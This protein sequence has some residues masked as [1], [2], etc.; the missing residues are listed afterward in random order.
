MSDVS[1]DD[2]I[3]T[4]RQHADLI[5]G[6]RKDFD[7]MSEGMTESMADQ[8]RMIRDTRDALLGTYGT[9]GLVETVRGFAE[10]RNAVTRAFWM[11]VKP[12]LALMGL[13][14]IVGLGY[15]MSKGMKH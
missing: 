8:T 4:L 2:I 10:W 12:V 3:R 1:N 6:L 7:T 13:A 15:L 5:S 11:I 14:V 9:T